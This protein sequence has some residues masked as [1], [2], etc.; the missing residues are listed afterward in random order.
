MKKWISILVAFVALFTVAQLHA[1]D[2]YWWTTGSVADSTWT[3]KGE[4]PYTI[5]L[6]DTLTF[7]AENGDSIVD[8]GAIYYNFQF[9]SLNGAG[10]SGS[11]KINFG[12][13]Q[14]IW[15]ADSVA[16]NYTWAAV[17]LNTANDYFF[18]P[19]GARYVYVRPVVGG[20][21]DSTCL[22]EIKAVR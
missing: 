18:M 9:L 16:R 22:L 5:F 3:Q 4:V 6:V 10:D 17:G 21:A 2:D 12:G 11:V 13:T 7:H 20:T 14:G 19:G 1:A 15:H 8:L